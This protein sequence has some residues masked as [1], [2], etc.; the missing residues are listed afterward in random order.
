MA[1]RPADRRIAYGQG[2][3]PQTAVVDGQ[4]IT[5]WRKFKAYATSYHPAAVGGGTTATGDEVRKGVVAVD[6]RIIPLRSTLFVPGYGVGTALDTGGG[7]R[8]RRVD[9]GYDDSDFVSL[10]KWVDVYLLW[11][12]PASG[13]ITWVLPN[14]PP[15][16]E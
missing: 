11:P 5:Y 6:P 15:V 14:Y 12:P 9:L 4:S 1:Q 10:S 7:I 3:E 8:S 16:P 13:D 2:I